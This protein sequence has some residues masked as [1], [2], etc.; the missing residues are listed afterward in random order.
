MSA[1]AC[2][3][4]I[5]EQFACMY[6]RILIYIASDHRVSAMLFLLTACTHRSN[7]VS[8]ACYM[9]HGGW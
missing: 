2:C 5:Y 7:P 8:V 9:C 3:F 4:Y 6:I 1:I